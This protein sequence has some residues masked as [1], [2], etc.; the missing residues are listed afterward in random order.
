MLQRMLSNIGDIP[1]T[2]IRV[3]M[4]V[5]VIFGAVTDAI[6]LLRFKPV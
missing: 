6:S 3:D 2:Q 1:L 4:P 5:T